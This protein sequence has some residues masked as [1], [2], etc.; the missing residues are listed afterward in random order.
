MEKKNTYM[1]YR[2]DLETG[3][4]YETGSEFEYAF[5]AQKEC[6]LVNETQIL[7]GNIQYMFYYRVYNCFAPF[8]TQEQ[9]QKE[10]RLSLD[11]FNKRINGLKALSLVATKSLLK[12]GLKEEEAV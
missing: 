1:V 4:V 3:K 8:K 5:D 2:I 11:A 10:A 9:L 7:S 6:D 12:S